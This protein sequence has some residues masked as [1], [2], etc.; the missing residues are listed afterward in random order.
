MITTA[1][2]QSTI[3]ANF[4]DNRIA[5]AHL[6]IRDLLERKVV[7]DGISRYRITTTP[8]NVE[9]TTMAEFLSN[10]TAGNITLHYPYNLFNVEPDKTTPIQVVLN[11]MKVN[12]LP[13]EEDGPFAG[14]S[15][16]GDKKIMIYL[17][18]VADADSV[19]PVKIVGITLR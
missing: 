6:F 14:M 18:Y 3:L 9:V 12:V 16:H 2:V 17:N 11:G 7:L 10:I 13:V 1:V 5:S 8:G 4:N 19:L 15:G